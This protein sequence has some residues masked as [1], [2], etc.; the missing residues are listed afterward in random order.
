MYDVSGKW[1]CRIIQLHVNCC[2]GKN[3]G[4]VKPLILK[5]KIKILYELAYTQNGWQ[6]KQNSTMTSIQK[7]TY[8]LQS[9]DEVLE[10]ELANK[11]YIR[12][13]E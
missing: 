10:I 6:R 9:I 3:K 2:C 1:E 12:I 4:K 11:L 13:Q 8:F 5:K 7:P